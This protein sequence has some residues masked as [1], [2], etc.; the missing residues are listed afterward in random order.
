[1]VSIVYIGISSSICQ[2]LWSVNTDEQ[3][4]IV[5]T[6]LI[7]IEKRVEADG[8]EVICS[9]THSLGGLL[10]VHDLVQLV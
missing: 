6:Y 10:H 1:M 5:V 2:L 7:G 3:Q 9:Q 8:G 4:L